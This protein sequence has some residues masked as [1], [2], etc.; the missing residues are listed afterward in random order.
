MRFFG[1][2]IALIKDIFCDTLAHL[3]NINIIAGPWQELYVIPVQPLV[4]AQYVNKRLDAVDGYGRSARFMESFNVCLLP[5]LA[6]HKIIV[7]LCF[8]TPVCCP[9]SC[10][11]KPPPEL[12]NHGV[13]SIVSAMPFKNIFCCCQINHLINRLISHPYVL[14]A[15]GF[16]YS[17]S[18]QPSIS[19]S[20]AGFVGVQGRDKQA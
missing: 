6:S 1:I 2:I 11:L 10:F 8:L 12:A 15:D 4:A 13:F 3:A 17:F 16:L 18:R 5:L 7:L 20:L 19:L 14:H 9:V